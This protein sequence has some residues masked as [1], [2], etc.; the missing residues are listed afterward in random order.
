[1][2]R[3]MATTEIDD[4]LD[5]L[6]EAGRR[7]ISIDPVRFLKVLELARAYLSIYELPHEQL[8]ELV[9]RCCATFGTT[10][11]KASA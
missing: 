5:D 4:G 7:L 8:P 2:A 9:A 6:A 10:N 11:S 3:I 1:M